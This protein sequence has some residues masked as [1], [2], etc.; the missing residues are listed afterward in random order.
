MVSGG[1]HT[2]SRSRHTAHL[3]LASALVLKSVCV[4]QDRMGWVS[5]Q[6]MLLVTIAMHFYRSCAADTKSHDQPSGSHDPGSKSHDQEEWAC[7]NSDQELV[8]E[9]G[10]VQRHLA[11]AVGRWCDM[12]ECEG[13]REGGEME[14]ALYFLRLTVEL[15]YLTCQVRPFYAHT[16]T[17]THARTHTHTHAHTHSSRWVAR[18][19]GC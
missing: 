10:E 17:R 8:M 15:C 16:H 12:G 9:D 4:L 1:D 5:R 13:V 3:Y 6:Q 18:Y 11:R 2:H 14:R 7:L 19:S